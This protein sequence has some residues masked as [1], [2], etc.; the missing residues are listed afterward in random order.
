MN[1]N[2][3]LRLFWLTWTNFVFL[4]GGKLWGGFNSDYDLFTHSGFTFTIREKQRK[5]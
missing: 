1:S 5:K 2:F 3:N 4:G